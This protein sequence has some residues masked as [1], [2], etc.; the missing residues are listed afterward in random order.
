[1]GLNVVADQPRE[2]IDRFSGQRIAKANDLLLIGYAEQHGS[3]LAVRE[4]GHCLHNSAR[5]FARKFALELQRCA[6][7]TADQRL[8]ASCRLDL[9]L[10]ISGRSPSGIEGTTVE[11]LPVIVECE[12]GPFRQ[13]VRQWQ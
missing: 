8:Y 13:S 1:V 6:L 11:Q 12:P 7:A 5:V 10:N 2:V 3:T 4:G 9:E